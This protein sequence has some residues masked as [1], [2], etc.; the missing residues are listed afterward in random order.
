LLQH[1]TPAHFERYQ[2]VCRDIWAMHLSLLPSPPSPEPL[3]HADERGDSRSGKAKGGQLPTPSDTQHDLRERSPESESLNN[4]GE[5]GTSSSY[6]SSSD[7]GDNSDRPAIDSGLDELMRELSEAEFSDDEEAEANKQRR[8]QGMAS[9][10]KRKG[11]SPYESPVA[12]MSVLVLACWTM[13]LPIIYMDL[14][15]YRPRLLVRFF[16]TN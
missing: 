3:I 5:D 11:H 16:F 4:S 13:R 2:V 1:K 7:A 9:R 10:K 14:I 8:P 12:N 15:R 6:S